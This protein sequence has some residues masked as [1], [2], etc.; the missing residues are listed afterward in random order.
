MGLRRLRAGASLAETMGPMTRAVLIPARHALLLGAALCLVTGAAW[1][2]TTLGPA[3]SLRAGNSNS[4]T[5]TLNSS[6]CSI[7]LRVRWLYNYSVGLLCTPLKVWSTDGE[8][9]ETPGTND[10]RYD[11]IPAVA[12]STAREGTF[13][14]PIDELPGFK[15]GTTTP[16]GTPGIT[17]TH[18]IC[19]VIE[20]S[21]ASCGFTNQPKLQASSLKIV[22]DTL[23][24]D[25]PVITE[26]TP[27]DSSVRLAFAVSSDAA[28]VTAEVRQQGATDWV[29]T[30]E[31]VGTAE[32][33][34]VT[35]LQNGTTY[36]LRLRARDAAENRSEPSD[37]VA[38][39]PIQTIGFWGAYR[40][41]GGTDR[42]GCSSAPGLLF[43][44]LLLLPLRRRR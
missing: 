22:Y 31:V 16:C 35:G 28:W 32:S 30:N 26:T 42:G 8:C 39:T 20:Y 12:L 4:D 3:V 18:K 11:D 7:D 9:G 33:I 37:V 38:A 29:S 44:A 6:E 17:K 27:L 34:K 24:P 1:A 10:V 41:K 36:D 25:A 5:Y 21:T 13:D 23:A 40:Y 14:V 43:P 2:Q 15:A 19:G